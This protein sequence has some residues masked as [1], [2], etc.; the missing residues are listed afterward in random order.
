[1]SYLSLRNLFAVVISL[2]ELLGVG[3]PEGVARLDHPP[4]RLAQRPRL[5]RRH[6]PRR[7]QARPATAATPVPRDTHCAADFT[8]VLG[9]HSHCFEDW[10]GRDVSDL[11][12]N[13]V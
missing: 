2:S 9:G 1:M 11:E 12:T 13:E 8:P 6:A 10:L 4:E 5:R 3:P 7:A